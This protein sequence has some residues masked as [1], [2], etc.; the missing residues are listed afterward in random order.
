M[1]TFPKT[2][3]HEMEESYDF[4]PVIKPLV[5]NGYN[6]E[7][8]KEFLN[9]SNLCSIKDSKILG[10]FLYEPMGDS[11]EVHAFVLPLYRNRSMSI[12]RAFRAYLT[13]DLGFNKIV[14][15]VTGDYEHL[16]RFLKMIGFSVTNIEVDAITKDSGIFNVT[17]LEYVKE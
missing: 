11:V 9:T 16:V 17:Y 5:G 4:D 7:D 3:F 8:F 12:L 2:T 10:F 1:Y 15:T 6:V 13:D 14:T